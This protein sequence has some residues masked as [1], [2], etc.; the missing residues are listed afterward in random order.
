M[1]T[2][3][4]NANCVQCE[5]TKRYLTVNDIKF[6][7]KDLAES[8]EVLPLIEEKGYK[9][10]PVIVTDDDSWSGFKIDKLHALVEKEKGF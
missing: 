5:Q 4:T 8:P 6:E 9:A 3:Y 1:I 7:V 10:A 2:V